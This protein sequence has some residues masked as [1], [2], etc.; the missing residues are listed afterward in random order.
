MAVRYKV[1]FEANKIY[2]ITF[3]ILEWQNIFTDDRYCQ[4]VYKWFDYMKERYGNKIHGYVIMPN[5]V[6]VLLFVSANSPV[7][8][9]LIQNAKRFLAYGIVKLLQEGKRH[10]LLKEFSFQADI[11]H[12]AK[13]KIFEDRYDSK[14]IENKALFIEKLNYIHNNPCSKKWRLV[15]LSQ[16]YSHSSAGNYM[17]GSGMYPVDILVE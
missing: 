16:D 1:P 11:R 2:F 9:K 4:L 7:I 3:T 13:H 14:L 17:F 15:E 12:G 6:H 5:H 10:D 8:W